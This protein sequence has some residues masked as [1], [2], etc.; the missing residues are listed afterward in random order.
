MKKIVLIIAFWAIS[1]VSHATANF[2]SATG[3][4]LVPDVSVDGTSHY[5]TVTL[6]LDF[7]TKSFMILDATPKDNSFSDTPLETLTSNGLKVDFFGCA[8]TGHN[9]ISCLTKVVSINNDQEIFANASTASFGVYADP[10]QI[11]D[12][13]GREYEADVTAFDLTSG[14][15]LSL[16]LIQGI[17]A[18]IIFIINNFDIQATSIA[19][20]KPS[21]VTGNNQNVDGD[22]RNISF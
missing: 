6:Q 2:T 14:G 19:A 1:T 10:A 22:F 20:F 18:E 9:Q 7:A 5:H 3:V 16:N 13:L 21:F 17:P 4:F 11:F 8:M 12:N 15:Y